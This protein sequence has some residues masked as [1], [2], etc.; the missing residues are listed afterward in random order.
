MAFPIAF[1]VILY[2]AVGHAGSPNSIE[3]VTDRAMC[4]I[5]NKALGV[6]ADKPLTIPQIQYGGGCGL[7]G[8]AGPGT[9]SLKGIKAVDCSLVNTKAGVGAGVEIE[10]IMINGLPGYATDYKHIMWPVGCAHVGDA[11]FK[12][13]IRATVAMKLVLPKTLHDKCT[14]SVSLPFFHDDITIK[15][16]GWEG[17]IK[18]MIMNGMH[19]EIQ[20]QMQA[21]IGADTTQKVCSYVNGCQ[22]G[23]RKCAAD[24]ETAFKTCTN[25]T[26]PDPKACEAELN[27][28]L[29]QSCSAAAKD[30]LDLE[31]ESTLFLTV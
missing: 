28:T 24:A 11:H 13:D 8:N 5:L 22:A 21:Q 6:F 1:I 15:D 31:D 4:F 18:Q 9:I 27:K 12:A 26:H 17:D 19:A 16:G 10:G 23:I 7:R 25:I 3:N 2:I 20:N 14:S 29:T 30:C